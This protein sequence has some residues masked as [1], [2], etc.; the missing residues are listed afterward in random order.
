MHFEAGGANEKARATEG[1][2]F[3]V[4]A[5]NV[6]DVLAEKTFDALA[7]FLN[8]I[9]VALVHF[10]FDIFSRLEGGDFAIDLVVPGDV[11]DEVF[12]DGKGL[13]RRDGDGILERERVHTRFTGEA[14]TA[15]DFG[16]AGAT[17]G[18][19]AI[20]ANGEIGRLMRLDG[21]ERVENDHAG[22]E[23]NLVVDGLA[24]RFVAAEDA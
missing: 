11:G 16:G 14:G 22:G 21:V 7:K 8:A 18:G 19:F 20:P 23:R 4:I 15:V 2:V 17:F 24:A 12:D 13:E 6:A 5:E 9:Y 3:G 1:I 10:P